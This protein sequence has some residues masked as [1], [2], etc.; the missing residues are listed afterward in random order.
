MNRFVSLNTFP[1]KNPE[2]PKLQF[3]HIVSNV[4]AEALRQ[5]RLF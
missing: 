2:E 1:A 3:K 4:R 5:N